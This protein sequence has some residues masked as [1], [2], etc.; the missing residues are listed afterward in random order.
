MGGSDWHEALQAELNAL[1]IAYA[2]EDLVE[3]F[4]FGDGATV[5]STR[6]WTYCLASFAVLA[7]IRIAE[8][9]GTLP[10]L[11]SP[12]AAGQFGL[13]VDFAKSRWR[14]PKGIWKP[15]QYTAS[16]HVRLP[17]LQ[18]PAA[19]HVLQQESA[20]SGSYDSAD[21]MC[22]GQ[23]WLASQSSDA[24]SEDDASSTTSE[25]QRG[26]ASDLVT[27]PSPDASE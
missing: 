4:K 24:V 20:D 25:S 19:V 23:P 2:S 27:E 3:Y 26:G 16:G 6:T 15:L 8:I 21:E 1:G 7:D 17:A 5:T 13:Q 12:D 14:V 10:G 9:P 11:L 18:Y 22:R